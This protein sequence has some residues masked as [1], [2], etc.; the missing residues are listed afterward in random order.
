V[1][2]AKADIPALRICAE[3][4]LD[5]VLRFTFRIWRA[6]CGRPWAA[7]G[8]GCPFRREITGCGFWTC[9]P[10]LSVD[11][12]RTCRAHHLVL[13]PGGAGAADRANELAVLDQ[14][15]ASA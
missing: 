11:R 5:L 10:R 12:S 1:V 9:K 15:N 4:K 14:R 2:R 6:H 3:N 13:R 8:D 7:G